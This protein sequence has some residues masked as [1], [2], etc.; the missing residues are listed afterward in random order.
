MLIRANPAKAIPAMLNQVLTNPILN[1]NHELR[2]S[3]KWFQNH[4]PTINRWHQELI[5]DFSELE[6]HHI[7]YKTDGDEISR[8]KEMEALIKR[9][10]DSLFKSKIETELR[11]NDSSQGSNKSLQKLKHKQK[12][13]QKRV[14]LPETEKI[15][16]AEAAENPTVKKLRVSYERLEKLEWKLC[17]L[18]LAIFSENA[19]LKKRLLIY[20][21]IGE[22][23]ITKEEEGEEIFEELLKL[24]LII[25]YQYIDPRIIFPLPKK[26]P[27]VS[28]CQ[29]HPSVRY[30]LITLARE[31]GL[32]DFDNLGEPH[33]NTNTSPRACV[34]HGHKD[35]PSTNKSNIINDKLRT[36]FNVNES[37]LSINPEW[38]IKLKSL[39]VLQLG[40]WQ[41]D[42]S[43]H[44]EVVDESFLL[45]GLRGQKH[46]KYLSLRGISRITSI[47]RSIA[48]ELVSLEILDLRAC[49]N[50]ESLPSNISSLKK[51]THLDVTECY[52]LE[53]MPKT[54]GEVYSLQVLKGFVIGKY[55]KKNPCKISDLKSLKNLKRL[56]VHIGIEASSGQ[57][58]V[59]KGL[60]NLTSLK[61]L[62]I[63]WGVQDPVDD[64]S[65][66]LP[67]SLEKLDLECVPHE[68]IPEWL[69]P[70]KVG[71]LKKLYI[72]GGNL[73]SLDHGEEAAK[74]NHVE[75]LRLEY[76]NHLEIQS[77]DVKN[78]FPSL[79]YEKLPR[80]RR[81]SQSGYTF[82]I[83]KD[84]KRFYYV[85]TNSSTEET[86][87]SKPTIEFSLEAN[88][89]SCSHF[90]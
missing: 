19:V 55:S 3:I 8:R 58:E 12:Q 41:D 48:K 54:L 24:E 33:F 16:M 37:Y 63:S 36:I 18:F 90:V 11:I 71:Q 39:V 30:M 26:F 86:S 14:E 53:S 6:R 35:L 62:K 60:E 68:Q 40:R 66:C 1:H 20:W 5:D 73:K 76:L 13:K 34:F 87:S 56:G 42:P 25:P 83:D 38:L 2:D 4:F 64:K 72:K 23:L 65:L 57:Q 52:L 70:S 7:H 17:L 77:Q 69:K 59:F 82:H 81:K 85:P 89:N 28:K 84:G 47:P 27:I 32:F 80:S 45:K 67:S 10:E 22:G 78:W 9:I 50:L 61:T 21:W 31:S 44:I 29:I 15:I 49:H 74:W 75:I 43:Y 51:L 46:L 88:S 79:K